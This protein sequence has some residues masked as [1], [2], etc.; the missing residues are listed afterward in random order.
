MRPVRN[1][2]IRLRIVQMFLLTYL[3]TYLLV[4]NVCTGLRHHP[5]SMNFVELLIRRPAKDWRRRHLYL[6]V[7]FACQLSAIGHFWLP[8]LT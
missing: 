7:A 6:S 3:L 5:L 2:D 8:R 1:C 4:T